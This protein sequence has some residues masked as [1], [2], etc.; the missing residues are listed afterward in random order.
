[1]SNPSAIRAGRAF[2]ELFA[3]DSK[4]VRGLR[5]AEAKVVQFGQ[6]IRTIGQR[7]F[8]M[9]AVAGGV[10]AVATREFATWGDS[11]SKMSGRTGVSVQALS[12]LSYAARQSGTDVAALE[13]ALRTMQRNLTL[14]FE[15]NDAAIRKLQILGLNIETLKRMSPEEQFLA[16]GEALSRM[17]DPTERSALAMRLLGKSGTQ[18]LPMFAN[19][20]SGVNALR[21]RCRELGLTVSDLDAANATKLSDNLTDV[22]L[23][24]RA[25]GFAIGASL[26]E[27]LIRLTERMINCIAGIAKWINKNRELVV[28]AAKVTAAVV[29]IGAAILVAG[30]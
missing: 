10:L 27:P 25:V 19:G 1:M 22:G 11:L 14:A 6:N 28:T 5:R 26:A 8:A 15:G 30:I 9:G 18:L 21:E 4:L 17:S 13:T 20:I 24:I 3:D 2:V 16:V 7:L 23:T 29:G 12:E